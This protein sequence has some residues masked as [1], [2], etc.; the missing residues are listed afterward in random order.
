MDEQPKKVIQ[1]LECCLTRYDKR[2]SKTTITCWKCDVCPYGEQHEG[3]I[4][5]HG[6]RLMRDALSMLKAQQ[7]KQVF[8]IGYVGT[9]DSQYATCPWCFSRIHSNESQHYCGHCGKAVKWNA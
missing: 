6:E 8:P 4:I 2:I 9:S 5:C 1:G 3:E 7:P